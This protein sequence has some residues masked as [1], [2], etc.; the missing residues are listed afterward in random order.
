MEIII[1]YAQELIDNF[2][3][4]N[5]ILLLE[6][7]LIET[8]FNALVPLKT[9]A[10]FAHSSENCNVGC[11]Y[12]T[13]KERSIS[14]LSSTR[15]HNNN[16]P[17]FSFPASFLTLY[18]NIIIQMIELVEGWQKNRNTAPPSGHSMLGWKSII[19]FVSKSLLSCNVVFLM[20][21]FWIKQKGKKWLC[22]TEAL[23]SLYHATI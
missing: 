9:S 22:N 12:Q 7:K 21:P 15:I 3:L 5:C 11:G 4:K 13:K 6:N 10:G 20:T 2:K 16:F 1:S 8:C 19:F 17:K 14:S 18:R 23:I